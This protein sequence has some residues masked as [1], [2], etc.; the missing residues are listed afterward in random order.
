MSR[1][2]Q[3]DQTLKD[4]FLSKYT[5][6]CS[7]CH[8]IEEHVSGYIFQCIA[9]AGP[10]PHK[11]HARSKA[12]TFCNVDCFDM[13]L[14]TKGAEEKLDKIEEDIGKIAD[15]PKRNNRREALAA[16][17]KKIAARNEHES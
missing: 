14:V 10:G 6:M 13:W 11:Y 2:Q 15:K 16:S 12:H 17:A 7:Q 9:A 3:M 5:T 1:N 4:E 8:K